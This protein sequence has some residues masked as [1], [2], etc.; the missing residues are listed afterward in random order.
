MKNG[1]CPK[2]NSANVY[3][4]I[5]GIEYG[6]EGGWIEIWMGTPDSR[7]G[8]QS[9]FESYLCADCGYFENYLLNQD[10]LKEVRLKWARVTS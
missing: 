6:D 4:N 2:C 5:S 3:K 9:T 8:K 10:V 1:K 7:S